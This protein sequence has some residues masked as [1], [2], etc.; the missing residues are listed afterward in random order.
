MSFSSAGNTNW[1]RALTELQMLCEMK[2]S[3]SQSGGLNVV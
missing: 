2:M 1:F 3:R